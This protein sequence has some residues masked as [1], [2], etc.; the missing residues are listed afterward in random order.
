LKRK[1]Q[2]RKERD[3]VRIRCYK[4]FQKLWLCD[5]IVEI[6]IY[7]LQ[8]HIQQFCSSILKSYPI[9]VQICHHRNLCII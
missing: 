7:R 9:K 3:R 2:W 4:S 1:V 8:F 5:F 6:K